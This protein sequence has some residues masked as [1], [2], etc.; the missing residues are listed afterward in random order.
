MI[1]KGKVMIDNIITR[2]GED[3][4]RNVV[5]CLLFFTLCVLLIVNG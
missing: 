3:R 1:E 5:I 2:V 4:C